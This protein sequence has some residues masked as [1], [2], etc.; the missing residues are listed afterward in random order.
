MYRGSV[1]VQHAWT[2]Y[3]S[4]LQIVWDKEKGKWVDLD[5]G[6][7]VYSTFYI[8][9]CTDCFDQYML[10][11]YVTDALIVTPSLIVLHSG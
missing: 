5:A 7:E 8:V 11:R 10:L 3:C 4:L 6:D 1:C 9:S 2:C